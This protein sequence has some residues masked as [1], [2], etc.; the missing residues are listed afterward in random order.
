[1][2]ATALGDD[3][4]DVRALVGQIVGYGEVVELREKLVEIA[5][6]DPDER[7]RTVAT[8]TLDDM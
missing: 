6:S 8:E 5:D 3:D 4:P 7:V 1:M 2:L